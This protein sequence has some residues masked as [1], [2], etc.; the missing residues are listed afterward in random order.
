MMSKLFPDGT[1]KQYSANI[2]AENM[3]RQE[4]AD[5]YHSQMLEGILE[6]KKDGR[7]AEKKDRWIVSKCGKRSTRKTTVG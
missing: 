3:L 7:A 4:D 5:E 6:H 2:I 1:V